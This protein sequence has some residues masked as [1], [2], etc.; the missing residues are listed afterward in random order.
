MLR[1]DPFD[2]EQLIA[3]YR[4]KERIQIF[5]VATKGSDC[6]LCKEI[7]EPNNVF[8]R[9]EADGLADIF[10]LDMADVFKVFPPPNR[11]LMFMYIPWNERQSPQTRDH[12]LPYEEMKKELA[13]WVQKRRS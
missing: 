10:L 5:C 9:L 1:I 2:A 3:Q 11:F 7:S 13:Y 4:S 12:Y 8:E 6:P